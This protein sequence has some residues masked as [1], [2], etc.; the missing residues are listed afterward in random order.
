MNVC[1]AQG[2]IWPMLS[3]GD[4]PGRAQ[5]VRRSTINAPAALTGD[6]DSQLKNGV[7]LTAVVLVGP[8]KIRSLGCA[9]EAY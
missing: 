4:S 3:T 8:T 7:I 1:D 6:N 5:L 9:T 2:A